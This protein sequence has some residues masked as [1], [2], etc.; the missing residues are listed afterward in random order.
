MPTNCLTKPSIRGKRMKGI[1]YRIAMLGVM[2]IVLITANAVRTHAMQALSSSDMGTVTAQQGISIFFKDLDASVVRMDEIELDLSYGDS[3]DCTFITTDDG[4]ATTMPLGDDDDSTG[5]HA[6]AMF[7]GSSTDENVPAVINW[8]GFEIDVGSNDTLAGDPD[9]LRDTAVTLSL[10]G[11]GSTELYLVTDLNQFRVPGGTT[12]DVFGLTLGEIFWAEKYI[13]PPEEKHLFVH[14]LMSALSSFDDYVF[15]DS[16]LGGWQPSITSRSQ[17]RSNIGIGGELGLKLG[18]GTFGFTGFRKTSG[19]PQRA[20]ASNVMLA[21][22]ILDQGN[23]ADPTPNWKTQNQTF[24]YQDSIDDW[25]IMGEAVVGVHHYRTYSRTGYTG[26]YVAGGNLNLNSVAESQIGETSPTRPLRLEMASAAFSTTPNGSTTFDCDNDNFPDTYLVNY[27]SGHYSRTIYSPD[28]NE[29]LMGTSTLIDS[30]PRFRHYILGDLR[31]GY[32]EEKTNDMDGNGVVDSVTNGGS[33]VVNDISLPYSKLVLC[34]DRNL[35][36]EI[37]ASSEDYL[38][39]NRDYGDN[40]TAGTQMS[41]LGDPTSTSRTMYRTNPSL[42]TAGGWGN[43]PY[44][45]GDT[46]LAPGTWWK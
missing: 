42:G 11:Y 17:I 41:F 23:T 33:W 35:V 19:S 28:A 9:G 38:I 6:M 5:E 8:L 10:K 46:A 2:V 16:N 39:P 31:I 12:Y 44:N 30:R 36:Q 24:Y 32:L 21:G 18:G 4:N 27:I 40:G 13:A 34:G 7:C 3:T 14:I 29:S 20:T 26:Q 25:N 45:P 37:S 15:V 1:I 22:K 43:P